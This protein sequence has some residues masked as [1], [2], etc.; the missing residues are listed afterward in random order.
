MPYTL[1]I[2]PDPDDGGWVILV[3]ELQG[4]MTQADHW[5]DILPLIE[6]A[7]RRWLETALDHNDPIPE[8]EPIFAHK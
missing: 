8:P 5:E 3:K 2:I 1:E 7:K 6:D 4:C